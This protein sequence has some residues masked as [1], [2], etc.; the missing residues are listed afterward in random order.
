[1]ALSRPASASARFTVLTGI[2]CVFVGTALYAHAA[3]AASAPKVLT[4]PTVNGTPWVG[5][6][7]TTTPGTWSATPAA[8]YTYQW[9]RC[10]PDTTSCTAISLAI[11]P[12]YVATLND[13]GKQ[14]RVKVTARNWVG[15]VATLSANTATVIQ[16]V[17]PVNTK[18]PAVSGAL[19]DGSTLTATS[20]TWTGTPVPTYTIQWQRCQ[21]VVCTAIGASGPSYVL[22]PGDVGYGIAVL[23]AATCAVG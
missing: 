8:T 21:G 20:G 3:N 19:V 22:R 18:A 13:K 15:A 2:L 23:V 5:K 14:L 1:M 7:L 16:A 10:T 9:Q 4:R 12:S 11:K 6:T 17:A